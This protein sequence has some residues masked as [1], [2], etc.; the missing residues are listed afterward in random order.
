MPS[1]LLKQPDGKIAIFS[2]EVDDFTYYGLSE[3][4][5]LEIGVEK[6]GRSAA[7]EKLQNALEDKRLME[8]D[9]V[10]DG[11]GRWRESLQTIAFQH[12]LKKLRATL[13]DIGFPDWDIH[14]EAIRTGEN[15]DEQLAELKGGGRSQ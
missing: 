1:Y 14:P 2:S 12:G 9:F 8:R 10:S 4:E 5:A 11:L 3:E 6:G 15:R 13:A 7:L